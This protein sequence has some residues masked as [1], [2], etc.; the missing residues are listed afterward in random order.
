[1]ADI[2]SRY[3]GNV[4]DSDQV[5]WRGDQVSTP[6]GGQSIYDSASLKLAELGARKVVGDRVFR[7]ALAGGTIKAAD[8]VEAQP[9]IELFGAIATTSPAGGKRVT[10]TATDTRGSNVFADGMF[11]VGSGT[12]SNCGYAY[13]V[14]SHPDISS[15]GNGVLTLYDP[16]KRA[17]DATDLAVLQANKY[18]GVV[19][20]T[21]GA[22]HVIAGV[23]PIYVTSGE[24]FWLQTWGPAGVKTAA[25]ATGAVAADATGQAITY[26]SAQAQAA[27]VPIGQA[28][29]DISASAYGIVFLQIAP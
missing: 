2:T 17:M 25:G 1:M 21:T 12:A 3:Q 15:A 8:V 13:K 22:A 27:H 11:M 9:A 7:Y 26:D 20:C 5:N 19:Q 28:M 10:I 6:Q 24:Y 29:M 14:K 18:A 4:D 16:I 23:A